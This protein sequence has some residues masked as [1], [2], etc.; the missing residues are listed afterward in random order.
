MSAVRST[1]YVSAPGVSVD[2]LSGLGQ[3]GFEKPPGVEAGDSVTLC[4]SIS[5]PPLVGV[6]CIRNLTDELAEVVPVGIL[7]TQCV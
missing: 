5:F 1:G 2:G 3:D 6:D 4:R 7:C